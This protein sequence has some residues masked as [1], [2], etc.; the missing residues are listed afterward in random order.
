MNDNH[1]VQRQWLTW[2]K[3]VCVLGLL[4]LAAY[5]AGRPALEKMFGVKLPAL[6]NN[7]Q[8]ADNDDDDK[9][10]ADDN[11][12]QPNAKAKPNSQK[13]PGESATKFARISLGNGKFKTPQGLL[14]SRARLDHVMRHAKN[15][16]NRDGP[17]GVFDVKSEDQVLALIDRAYAKTK[18]NPKTITHSRER[19]KHGAMRDVYSI[20]MKKRIGWVGGEIRS[21]PPCNYLKLVLENKN[22]ITAYPTNRR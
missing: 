16:P 5:I 12:N 11:D 9:N 6:I 14:Y 10:A 7:Q 8:V 19:A 1:P 15:D 20:N 2:R 21:K 13:Q 3:I 22:V 18:S 4:L 17:H